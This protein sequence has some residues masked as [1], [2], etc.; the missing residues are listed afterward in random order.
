MLFNGIKLTSE[1]IRVVDLRKYMTVLYI[2]RA[3]RNSSMM[4]KK[5]TK[6]DFY[7]LPHVKRGD[8]LKA[9]MNY[10]VL[11]R[12]GQHDLGLLTYL[13]SYFVSYSFRFYT[14]AYASR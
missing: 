5:P 10:K 2:I 1:E 12:V 8:T 9:S 4:T 3:Q 14:S 13:L 6:K 7:L 11:F